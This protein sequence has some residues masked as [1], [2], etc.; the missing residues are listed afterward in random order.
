LKL[1]RAV[2]IVF[3]IVIVLLGVYLVGSQ[4]NIAGVNLP[5]ALGL[6]QCSTGANATPCGGLGAYGGAGVGSIVVIFGLG[7]LAASFRSAMMSASMG[8]SPGMG[9]MPPELIATLQAAQARMQSMPTAPP[10]STPS[11]TP[12]PAFK[13]CS[14]CGTR[15]EVASRFCKSCGTPF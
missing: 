6:P 7:I 3:G 13:F 15:T 14:K 10:S 8:G 11:G 1:V 12:D 2:P 5:S 9:A 4:G